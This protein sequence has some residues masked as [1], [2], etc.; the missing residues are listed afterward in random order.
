[1]PHFTLALDA[2]GGGPIISV[3]VAVSQPRADALT[4]A[5]TAIPAPVLIRALVDTGAS[6]TCIDPGVL[7]P[8]GLT[9]TGQMPMLTPSTGA[10]PQLKNQYDVSLIIPSGP[11]T[12]LV[13]SAIPIT[14]SDL[15]VQGIQ[16]LIG[17][18][19]LADCILAYNG[20][21]RMFTLAF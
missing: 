2:A 20:T 14:E 16:A 1:L 11:H 6:C 9:P 18:D 17:R 7:T 21:M 3:Y 8:L 13:F 5:G 4:A 12:P 15:A 19:I 10:V